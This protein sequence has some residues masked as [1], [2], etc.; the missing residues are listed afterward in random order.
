MLCLIGDF[1]KKYFCSRI[2]G[3]L[4]VTVL[5]LV[6]QMITLKAY[7]AEAVAPPEITAK[8]AIA[9]NADT[10]EV[11]FEKY[12][13]TK[14][15]PA[16]LTKM[17]TGIIALENGNLDMVLEVSKKAAKTDYGYLDKPGEKLTAKEV[18]LSMMLRSDNSAATVIA[19]WIA[20]NERNFSILMN[21]KAREIGLANSHFVTPHGLPNKNHYSTARDMAKIAAYAW[22]NSSFRSIVGSKNRTISWVYPAGKQEIATN[23]NELLWR[24]PDA[25]GIKTGWTKAAGGCLSVGA[26]RDDV[27]IIVVVMGASDADTRFDDAQKIIEFCFEYMNIGDM[28]SVSEMRT[29][30]R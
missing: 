5:M 9:I 21:D 13:D 27:Q 29:A 8:H 15:Y 17:L 4:I 23:T 22:K 14:A 16:S 2:H 11:L 30:R 10:G 19:E 20:G 12:P 25:N 1:M 24:M 3:V 18:L 28:Y 26:I 6:M 7:A